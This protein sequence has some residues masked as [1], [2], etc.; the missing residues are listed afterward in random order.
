MTWQLEYVPA[1]QDMNMLS[2]FALQFIQPVL[3]FH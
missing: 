3:W 2:L 1:D